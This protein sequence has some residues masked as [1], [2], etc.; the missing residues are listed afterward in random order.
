MRRPIT[1]TLVA[2]VVMVGLVVP[3]RGGQISGT[4]SGDS[5]L[6]PT[7]TSGVFVQ[8]FTGDGADMQFGPF[9]P[10]SQSIINFRN[11][12][13]IL[14]SDGTFLETFPNGTLFGTSS[15]EGTASGMQTAKVTVDFVFTGGTGFFAGTTG[16]ATF[17]GTI[18]TTGP[19]AE[20]I[21]GTYVGQLSIPEPSTLAL[22]AP[23]AAVVAVVVVRGRRRAAMAQ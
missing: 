4:L 12:P 16:E 11:P 22:F 8:N 19:M 5:T 3:V 2:V 23:A 9:T 6:T 15:G 17:T 7:H 21:D 10:T 14:I 1:A 20:A 13:N 18:T